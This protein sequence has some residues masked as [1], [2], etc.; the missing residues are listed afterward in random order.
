MKNNV[1]EVL[2]ERLKDENISSLTR[3]LNLPKGLLHRICKEGRNPSLSN[4]PALVTLC[5][6][7]GITLQ[8]LLTGSVGPKLITS[9]SF[10]DDGTTYLVKIEKK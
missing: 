6:Y 4:I 2:K 8:E 5:D 10:T 3:K 9:L 1:S 7:L